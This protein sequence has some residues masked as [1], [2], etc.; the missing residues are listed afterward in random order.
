MKF[1]EFLDEAIGSEIQTA[2]TRADVKAIIKKTR[3]VTVG[4]T[5]AQAGKEFA[6]VGGAEVDSPVATKDKEPVMLKNNANEIVYADKDA[7][8]ILTLTIVNRQR[9]TKRSISLDA[10][11]MALLK[12]YI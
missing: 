5:V 2:E 11:A 4:R 12:R 1:T 7:E 6:A 8:G 9:Q 3:G 10:R